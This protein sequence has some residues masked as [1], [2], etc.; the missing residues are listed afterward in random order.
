MLVSYTTRRLYNLIA[1]GLWN[2][3]PKRV[4]VPYAKSFYMA[5]FTILSRAGLVKFRLNLGRLWSKTKYF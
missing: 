1:E 5:W 3:Q 4:K 2:E